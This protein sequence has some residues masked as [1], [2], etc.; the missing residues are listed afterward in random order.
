M[1]LRIV[2]FSSSYDVAEK[3]SKY[4]DGLLYA[5]TV[6]SIVISAMSAKHMF[7]DEQVILIAINSAI[8]CLLFYFDNSSNYVFTRA[9][10]KRRLDF[11]DN[12]FDTKFSGKKSQEYF[13]NEHLSPGLYKLA[14]NSF[15]NCHHS[16]FT[17]STMLPALIAKTFIIIILFIF[18]AYL[19]N[20]EIMRLFFELALPV[21]LAQKLFKAWCYSARMSALYDRFKSLF[22]DLMKQDFADKTPEALRLILDYETALAWASTPLSSKIFWKNKDRLAQEWDELKLEY[23]IKT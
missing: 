2:P 18:S 1:G 21:Y 4:S 8:I 13:T 12:A 5:S 15:E 17:I 23:T 3:Y 7:K 19:G 6:L 16:Q 20:G 10:M 9:E 22:N 11:L 14:V